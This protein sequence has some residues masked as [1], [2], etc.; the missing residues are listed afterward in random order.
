MPSAGE[1]Y[2][3]H[4]LGPQGAERMFRA[5]IENPDQIAADLFPRAASVNR[6]IFYDQGQPR[7]IRQVYRALV[8]QHT[9][10]ATN[11]AFDAQQLAGG[12][13]ALDAANGVG[14]LAPEVVPS[15]FE[16]DPAM[17]SFT[18]LFSNL[19]G[20]APDGP[21]TVPPQTPFFDPLAGLE[22]QEEDVPRSRFFDHPFSQ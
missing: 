18:T 13:T 9:G 1:L 6:A 15:R 7:T 5:G 12:Q 22:G 2:I 16:A 10:P 3:A 19:Q 8:A 11:S 20:A 4:F 14:E 21:E 17:M